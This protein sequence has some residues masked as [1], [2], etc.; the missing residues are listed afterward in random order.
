MG[1]DEQARASPFWP[2]DATPLSPEKFQNPRITA[3][4]APRA[5]V[6]LSALHT[7]W[8]NTGSL[9]NIAC[10]SCFM[11]SSPRNDSL[12]YLSAADVARYLDE[13]EALNLPTREIGF[14]GG[15]PF[16]NRDIGPMLSDALA[17]GFRVLV[18]TNAMKPLRLKEALVRDLVRAYG[19][20]LTLR[21]SLD[22]HTKQAHEAER[23]PDAWDPAIDGLR[24]LA[25]VGARL[26]I[27]GR[28]LPGESEAAARAGYAA[29]VDAIGLHLDADDP[30]RLVLFPNMDETADAPEVTEAC[31]EIVGRKPSDLMC[32]SSRMVVRRKGDAAPSI[33][34]CTLLPYDRRFDLG[35]VLAGAGGPVPL[36]HPHC[37]RF[38]V[39]GGARCSA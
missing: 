15:E 31:W 8:F 39:L 2:P 19:E 7:L 14:T 6:G 34:P 10:A 12:A 17:R 26:A 18:L 35:P 1:L 27:A 37:S 32:A 20:R 5:A 4:G 11:E 21:V 30:E 24:F 13:I 36:N 9:C 25:S 3:T 38:C 28:M 29:L 23:G 33:V 22:H 16:M